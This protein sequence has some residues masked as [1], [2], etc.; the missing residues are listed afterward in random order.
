[1]LGKEVSKKLVAIQ[2]DLCHEK[3]IALI[4]VPHT[5]VLILTT[6]LFSSSKCKLDNSKSR[7]FDLHTEWLGF[8]T[9]AGYLRDQDTYCPL[10]YRLLNASNSKHRRL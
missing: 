3:S 4:A 8:R 10:A 9:L 7:E 1:M 6:H 5:D 2:F